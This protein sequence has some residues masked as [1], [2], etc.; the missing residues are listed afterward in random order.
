MR[1]K[2]S[3]KLKKWPRADGLPK[4]YRLR[5]PK[6]TSPKFKATVK[7][8]NNLMV[9]S[10]FEKKA[11]AFFEKN[12]IKYRYEPLMLLG[13]KQY[14]PDFFLPEMNLYLELGGMNHLVY[15]RDRQEYKKQIYKK[16]GLNALFVNCQKISEVELA[17]R[18]A[19]EEF[20]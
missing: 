1:P 12:Q 6:L 17:L 7:T 13:G 8:E 11:I 19:L 20:R 3:S 9:R 5:R 18:E 15:Y 4:E 10:I 14:R 2:N 16:Y